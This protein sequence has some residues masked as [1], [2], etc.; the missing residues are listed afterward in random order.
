[1]EP[2]WMQKD[3]GAAT[4]D[5]SAKMERCIPIGCGLRGAEA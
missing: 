3:L 4:L 2:A 5:E 1:M